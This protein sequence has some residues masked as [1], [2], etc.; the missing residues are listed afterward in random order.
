MSVYHF[1]GEEIAAPASPPLHL[2]TLRCAS[3]LV[4][5]RR[6]L[7][8]TALG[9]IYAQ[10]KIGLEAVKVRAIEEVGALLLAVNLGNLREL[11]T[12]CL[13]VS[14]RTLLSG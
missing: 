6:S 12:N 13:V 4:L 7:N 10:I 11:L 8:I 9:L 2:F 1:T 5:F 3:D 14:L